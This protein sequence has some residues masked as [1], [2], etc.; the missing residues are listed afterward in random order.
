MNLVDTHVHVF[1]SKLPMAADRRYTPAYDATLADYQQRA[2]QVGVTHAVLVQPSF[3]GYDNSHMLEFLRRSPDMLRGIAVVPADI[4]PDALEAMQ[5]EGVSGIRLN[6]D[7]MPLPAFSSS[8][9]RSL[10]A[11]LARLDMLVEVHREA[12]DL[13]ALLPPLV[14]AGV[15]VVVDH[16]GRPDDLQGDRDPGFRFLLSQ[17]ETGRVWVKLSA[18]Y[19]NGWTDGDP[20]PA[21]QASAQ[22]M[23]H[24]G[25]TRL[26]WGSDWPHT[27]HE[28]QSIPAALSAL[29][30]WVPDAVQRGQIQGDTALRLFGF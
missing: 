14:D 29:A 30:T 22:L 7:G 18:G 16:F 24:F 28:R 15:R 21:I 12:R 11:N 5:R 26:V 13:P 27:R 9:W 20:S 23:A 25:G 17:A 19:R 3:L 6:L 4:A 8:A 10:L 2:G 1:T